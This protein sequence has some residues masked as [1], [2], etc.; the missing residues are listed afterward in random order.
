MGVGF[1][2]NNATSYGFVGGGMYTSSDYGENWNYVDVGQA[3]S[4]VAVLGSDPRHLATIY[5]GTGSGVWKSEDHGATWSPSGLSDLQI[6]GIAVD[7]DKPRTVYAA[8]RNLFYVSSNGGDTWTLKSTLDIGMEKLL[9]VPAPQPTIYQYGWGG[10]VRSIDGGL[11]WARAAGSLGNAKINTI[12]VASV[13]GRVILYVGT[14]GGVAT[15]TPQGIQ[16]L[17][18]EADG[19]V[20]A[21]VYRNTIRLLDLTVY[22]PTVRK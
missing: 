20:N 4:P 14:G 18:T 3:I 22:L 7:P 21:G 13:E 17:A 11:H 6:T 9:I 16:G 12:S 15:G 19:I 1:A 8:N 10:M 2:D 5:A